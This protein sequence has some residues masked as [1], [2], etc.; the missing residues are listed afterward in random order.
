MKKR[1][2]Q[3]QIPPVSLPPFPWATETMHDGRRVRLARPDVEEADMQMDCEV[4]RDGELIARRARVWQV[5]TAPSLRSFSP[6]LRAAM[7]DYAETTEAVGA[8]GGTSD[9]TGGGGGGA[10]RCGP[11]LRALTAAERLRKMDAALEGQHLTVIVSPSKRRANLRQAA[12]YRQLVRWLAVDGLSRTA[13]LRKIGANP[14]SE[15]AQERFTLAATDAAM[16]LAVTCGYVERPTAQDRPATAPVS[17][18]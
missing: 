3:R 11:S 5:A 2:Q 18:I 9:P 10:G 6:A 12:S 15:V 7:M 4:G 16:L 8:S 1:R 14:D 13:I 17:R